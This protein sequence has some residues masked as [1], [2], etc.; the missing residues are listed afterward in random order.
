[1]AGAYLNLFF[2]QLFNA[3]LLQLLI[4]EL[5]TP[6]KQPT[7]WI[8]SWPLHAILALFVRERKEWFVYLPVVGPVRSQHVKVRHILDSVPGQSRGKCT[9]WSSLN[10]SWRRLLSKWN[11][12]SANITVFDSLLP[13]D[14]FW[15]IHF[16]RLS[17][18]S[19]S[20]AFAWLNAV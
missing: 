1:M 7:T 6:T 5:L 19:V 4:T 9:G 20:L 8:K 17:Y 18:L 14:S 15:Q 3:Q 2:V 10:N 11:I 16:L 12:Y 13:K